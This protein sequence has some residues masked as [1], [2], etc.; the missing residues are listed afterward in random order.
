[1][2]KGR[3]CGK[4]SGDSPP[5]AVGL[6]R[7]LQYLKIRPLPTPPIAG[8]GLPS[9]SIAGSLNISLAP[10]GERGNEHNER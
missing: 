7:G 4:T 9:S 6:G 8:G 5:L 2:Q 1:M 3:Q 10:S